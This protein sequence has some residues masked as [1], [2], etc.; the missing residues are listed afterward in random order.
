MS[1]NMRQ[2]AAN[3]KEIGYPLDTST[4]LKEKKTVFQDL[5]A[6]EF[7]PQPTLPYFDQ[8]T[9]VTRIAGASKLSP[10]PSPTSF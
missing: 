9:P 7:I 8:I 6:L 10:T 2:D 1:K 3:S 5:K 4:H